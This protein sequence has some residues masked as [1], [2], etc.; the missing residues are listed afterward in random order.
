MKDLFIEKNFKYLQ[1]LEDFCK[2]FNISLTQ[3]SLGWLLTHS[4]IP[5][6]ICGVRSVDQLKENVSAIDVQF[7]LSDLNSILRIHFDDIEMVP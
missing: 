6:V 3:L 2:K 7:D 1:D 4:N 5:S